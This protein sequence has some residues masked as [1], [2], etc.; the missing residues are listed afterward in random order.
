MS[1][2][3]GHKSE[4]GYATVTTTFGGLDYRR[5]AEKMTDDGYK[6]NHATARNVFLKA[7]KKFAI[8]MC[9][10]HDIDDEICVSKTSRDPR[11]QEGITEII[12]DIYDGEIEI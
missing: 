1:M 9:A 6:M 5:I 2:P 11:F 8:S 10:I 7:M 4:N 12:R 3:K